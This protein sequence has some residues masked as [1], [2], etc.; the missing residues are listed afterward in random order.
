[1]IYNSSGEI[2]GILGMTQQE[3]LWDAYYMRKGA[4]IEMYTIRVVIREDGAWLWG[5]ELIGNNKAQDG[6]GDGG[7][8][9]SGPDE[10]NGSGDDQCRG[11][12]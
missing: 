2:Q 10:G 1:M 4:A 12:Q 11:Q 3:I 6:R 9:G 8:K 7:G 5:E